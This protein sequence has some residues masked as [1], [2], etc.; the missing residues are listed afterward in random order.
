[1]I[2]SFKCKETR[3]LFFNRLSKKFIS[4]EHSARKKLEMLNAAT[5]LKDLRNPPGNMLESLVG[6]RQG[7]YS[8]RI[9]KQFRICFIW[10]GK[11][12]YDVEVVDYH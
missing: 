9:N 8:I 7:Q 12:V 3:K 2:K 5:M 10:D 1:M 6:N 11:D 4:I